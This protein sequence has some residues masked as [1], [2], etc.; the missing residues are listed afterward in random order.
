MEYYIFF[1]DENGL[2]QIGCVN[3]EGVDSDEVMRQ[4]WQQIETYIHD[5]LGVRKVWYYNIWNEDGFTIFDY[6]SHD[7]FLKVRPVV[8]MMQYEDTGV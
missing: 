3:G 1:E 5:V 2:H 7:R 6:G 4:L 8:P